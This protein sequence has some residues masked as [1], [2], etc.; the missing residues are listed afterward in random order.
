MLGNPD[1]RA[2][3]FSVDPRMG[4][5]KLTGRQVFMW[6]FAAVMGVAAAFTLTFLV[7]A[8]FLVSG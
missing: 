7:M 8:I 3:P 6:V 2:P 4:R 5:S 1:P